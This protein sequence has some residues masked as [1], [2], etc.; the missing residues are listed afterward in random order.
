MRAIVL[1][2]TGYN[3]VELCKVPTP[4]PNENQI[5]ARVDAAGI[6]TSLLKLIEQ[7]SKHQLLSGW[8]IEKW[9][10]I[11]GDE[12]SITLVDVGESLVNEYKPGD[13]YVIQ[14][15]V[16]HKP[17]NHTER[18]HNNG[19]GIQK[20]AVGY[21]LPGHLAE[22]ILI[23]EEVIKAGCL[24]P[25]PD[26]KIPYAHASMGEPISCVISSQDHHMHL[27]QQDGIS[28]RSTQKGLLKGGITVV[29]G[30]GAMG[31][32]HIELA[33]SYYPEKI[34]VADFIEHRLALVRSKFKDRADKNGISLLTIN[35]KDDD[36]KEFVFSQSDHRG[37]DDVII[38]VGAKQA[39][40]SATGYLNKGAVLNI[41]GGLKKGAEIVGVD[42]NAVH[43]Q[44]IN[45]TGSSGGS[46][47]DVEH[48]L[49][50]IAKKLIDP[51]LHIT[52]IGDL[53]HAKEFL[54]L[55]KAQKIDGKA[56]VYP[57]RL[58]SEIKTVTHWTAEDESEYLK[59]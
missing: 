13:R 36:L 24:R 35:P 56:I 42:G 7:G 8:D 34:I 57:Y 20:V 4:K 50:L 11:L 58:S 59:K 3:S 39:I 10:I 22:Y 18:Y 1:K 19:L 14:P 32:I 38:A 53:D 9:P 30:A 28:Q 44:S 15:A 49:D 6:C 43:Y 5:L 27:I 16:D 51:S 52:R 21:S 23:P 29:V 31:R 45:I 37:A 33:M 48:T 26:A 47:W 12:G 25:I 46:P 17:I 41:F 40:E 54:N 2:G 55:I